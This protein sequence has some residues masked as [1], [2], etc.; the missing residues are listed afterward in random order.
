MKLIHEFI[1]DHAVAFPHKTVLQDPYGE[2]S[3]GELESKSAAIS[4]ILLNLGVRKG[5]AVAVYVPYTK[6]IM[7]GAIATLRI[8]C[9]FV[10][11]DGAYPEKRLE[12]MLED[13]E[14][15]AILT[16]RTFWETK[17]LD[18]PKNRVVF[19]DENLA[20][21]TID[22][23]KSPNRQIVQ[24][25]NHP[26]E[27]DSPAMLLYTSGTTGKPKGVLH[28]HRMLVHIADCAKVYDDAE[29]NADTR[30]GVMSSF[31]FV[32]T[33]MFLMGPLKTGG[34]VC[35]APE[36]A[37]RDMD[38]LYQFIKE[39]HITHIFLPSS[40]A[41]MMAEDY[42]LKGVFIFAAGEKLRNFRAFS[43][44]N[45][46]INLYGSTEVCPI[47]SKKIH[48]NEERILVGKPYHN[49]KGLIVD[50]D[51][52]PLSPGEVGELLV[53]N[54]YMSSG[55]YKLPELSAEKWITL[56]GERWF[57]TGDRAMCT[58][59]G[60]YDIL[61]RTDNM[62]KLRGFRIET[63]EV[64]AQIAN[65]V[66][67]LNRNDVGQI[68][69][70]VKFLSG[71][72]HLSCYYEAPQELD[73]KAVKEEI[74]DYLAEYMIPDVWVR[75]DALPRNLNGKVMRKDLPAP[76]R[77]RKTTG[78][79]DSE[80]LFRVLMTASE[81]LEADFY[82]SPE[83]R[84]TDVGGT[85]INAMKLAVTLREQGIKISGSQIL[86]YN[87]FRK[88]AD[89][90]TVV[91]E[92]LWS[93]EVYE[94]I[95]RD[96]SSRGEHIEKVLP[97]ANW[98]DEMLFRQILFPDS[99]SLRKAVFLQIDGIVSQQHLR[100]ALDVIAQENE[101]LRSAIVFHD[102]PVIQQV[103]TDR[104][105]PLEIMTAE[106]FNV[107][108]LKQLRETLLN[109]PID[110]QYNCMMKL[111]CLYVGNRSFLYVM[112]HDIAVSYQHYRRYIARLMQ[113]LE[114]HYPD[115][116]S[117]NDWKVLMEQAIDI[118][119]EEP[120]D[121]HV[122]V[123]IKKEVSSEIRVYSEN[124]GP[125]MVFV[126]TANT[127]SDAYYRLAGRIGDKVSFA[128]IEPY[129]LY[130]PG[131]VRH[132]IKDI[133]SNY[134]RILRDYQPEGP[135]I[136]GGWC[137]GGVVAHEMACQLKQ[138]GEE[139]QHLIM[140]DSHALADNTLR[141]MSWG[142]LSE[143]NATYFET[144]PL[145]AELREAGML[146]AMIRNAANVA[147]DLT[148]HSPSF[149]DGNVTYFKPDQIPAGTTG[150]NRK[151]WEKMMEFEAGNYENYCDKEKLHIVHTPHEHDLMMDDAS[152][153]I[154]IPEIYKILPT[155][156]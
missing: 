31:P 75:M 12:Y 123:S 55:Y 46:L 42:D 28:N 93:L 105:I 33:M 114:N 52:H 106:A 94:A 22:N 122:S 101:E 126:H 84:F 102:V 115:N 43:P 49:T 4:S 155:T 119:E 128:V 59:A 3:Y 32:A 23:S 37:R 79:I 144:C 48:G 129:N 70:V 15:A 61:G 5:D 14:A 139:V 21:A 62:V 147:E 97:I 143:V 16:T 53:T 96:F 100:E 36:T 137:Y 112:A 7:L 78:V 39:S 154:I 11:F 98:Q 6:E 1:S 125:R 86:Q 146:E 25:S 134:I 20:P 35:I 27:W 132:S 80:V 81:V 92:Q 87:S 30:S 151:Y 44:D 117:I 109:E 121:R 73:T 76:K 57:R 110:L 8:G 138:A 77:E 131:D 152:L 142:M 141:R 135:Y 103:I 89:S 41:A 68:V 54:D 65:A 67:R 130:H 95:L 156:N 26:I 60:D 74:A 150:D 127:G 133:A 45:I 88:I 124:D 72:D 91:Y 63:G 153:D 90:A 69:V 10:P 24:S 118:D 40:L 140:L 56:A 108:T 34:T 64:E 82:I 116:A 111:V 51:L 66:N 17:K 58:A 149:F 145:F 47:I 85:S 13:S 148:H 71:T 113:L 38:T 2:M 107:Q 19:L 29:M 99:V 9:I 120:N 18:F 50:D 136:L 104:K 83:D